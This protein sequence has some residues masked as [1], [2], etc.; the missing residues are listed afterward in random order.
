MVHL[1][2]QYLIIKQISFSFFTNNFFFVNKKYEDFTN[3]ALFE[4]KKIYK[5]VLFQRPD[6]IYQIS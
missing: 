2:V 6:W 1:I 3:V 4:K 5:I